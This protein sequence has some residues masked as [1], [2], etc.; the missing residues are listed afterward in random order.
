[1]KKYCIL[2]TNKTLNRFDALLNF[3][4]KVPNEL[5]PEWHSYMVMIALSSRVRKEMKEEGGGEGRVWSLR[6]GGES[7]LQRN[8]TT[9]SARLSEDWEREV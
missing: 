6:G 7:L 4:I 9:Q 8:G 2:S 3:Q 5:W 1:M